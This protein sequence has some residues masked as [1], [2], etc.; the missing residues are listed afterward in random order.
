MN[1]KK[2]EELNRKIRGQAKFDNY[3]C[4][5]SQIRLMPVQEPVYPIKGDCYVGARR[6][7]VRYEWKGFWSKN[8]ETA[9]FWN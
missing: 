6:V 4:Q 8:K 1:K 3:R 7:V 2:F 9:I 5:P